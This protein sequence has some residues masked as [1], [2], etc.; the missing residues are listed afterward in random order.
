MR[1]DSRYD[2]EVARRPAS[3]SSLAL[4]A[5]TNPLRRLGPGWDIDPNRVGP[6]HSA[7][8]AA[9]RARITRQFSATHAA[10][11]SLAELERPLRHRFTAAATALGALARVTAWLGSGA[12][13]G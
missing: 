13:A 12:I 8:A 4:A 2:I 7:G 3:H 9:H 1:S 6:Q 10:R 11:A 5:Q